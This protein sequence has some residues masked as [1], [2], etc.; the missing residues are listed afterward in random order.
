MSESEPRP[1]Q[2]R[3]SKKKSPSPPTQISGV[4]QIDPRQIFLC[5]KDRWI[6]A[7]S[8]AIV[9][10]A[11]LGGWLL[12]Q[13][14]VYQASS[15]LLVDRAERVVD[16]TQVVD[17][18][19]SGAKNDAMF[20]TYLAQITSRPMVIRVVDSLSEKERLEA[21][22][23]YLDGDPRLS[24]ENL[25][26]SL[27]GLVGSLAWANRAGGTF[28]IVVGVRHRDPGVAAL[29]ATRFAEQFIV[30][31]VDR[32]S[33]VNNS[34]LDFLREQTEELRKKAEASELSLQKYR[35]AS[36]MVSLDESQNIVVDRMKSLSS[37]VTGARVTRLSIEARLRQAESILEN[38]GDP[39]ELASTAEFS[40]LATVQAQ[41]DNLHA[42]RVIMAE[43][44][45]VKHPAMQ[46]NLRSMEA[47]ERLRDEL[48]KV[49]MANLRNQREKAISEEKELS[50]QLAAAEQES[51]RL[52]QMGIQFNVLRREAETNRATYSQLLNRLN[53]TL[54]SSQLENSNIRLADRASVP[55]APIE[56]DGRKITMM[57]VFL[58]LGIV[59]AYPIGLELLFNRVKTWSDIENFLGTALLAELPDLKK[60]AAKEKAHLLAQGGDDD[61]AEVVRGMHAQLRLNSRIDAPKV[62]LV[63]STVPGE[64]KS[65]VAVNLAGAFAA[66]GQKTLLLDFD[67]RRPVQHRAFDVPNTFGI[68]R[69]LEKNERIEAITTDPTLDPD[70]GIVRFSDNLSLLRA[71]GSTRRVTELI[72]REPLSLLIKKLK[73]HYDV[74]IVDTPPAG[75]FPDAIAMAEN[76]SELVF[77]VRYNHVARP[78]VKRVLERFQALGVEV[79]V[80]VLNM[81][82]SG[83]G[84]S[85][86]YS[87]YGY[88]GSKY[89]K[90]YEKEGK[91]SAAS[92]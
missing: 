24:G 8:I 74:I 35:E 33:A 2:V 18:S 9:V 47:L 19:V 23:P 77:V 68:L 38:K 45:G 69:W 55:G 4:P 79:P 49:A 71:G 5:I 86:Y 41:I 72:N 58:G 52:D 80:V 10:C 67:L 48:I 73:A 46:E 57:L 53:E 87:G 81:M 85:M 56:P 1:A 76:A 64:G 75:V 6:S 90:E 60:L 92:A 83:R 63:T 25:K 3:P 70:L 40:N 12:S 14:K 26:K 27:V 65:F 29:L 17:Q 31:L 32:S 54:V 91:A 51:L 20:E 7:F 78:A 82:P 39:L 42:R 61:A 88:Y 13:P 11:C 84:S 36:G 44:Y 21:M 30:H 28:F 37:T 50:L 89:Y 59:V 34:A 15:R 43:K 66:H 22:A 16:I 62:V